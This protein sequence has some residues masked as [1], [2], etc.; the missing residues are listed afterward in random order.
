[1]IRNLFGKDKLK[2]FI[3]DGLREWNIGDKEDS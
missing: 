3:S 2:V 1:M